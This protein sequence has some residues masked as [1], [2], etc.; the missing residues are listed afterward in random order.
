MAS[1]LGFFAGGFADTFQ[2][3]Q[4]LQQTAK[5]TN[6]LNDQLEL[7]KQA[8]Q[9]RAE[10]QES[11]EK[12][13]QELQQTQEAI[14]GQQQDRAQGA[15]T[16]V[17]LNKM[18]T[19]PMAQRGA[20]VDR[21]VSA[22][23]AEGIET[24]PN[25]INALKKTKTEDLIP[26]VNEWT[27]DVQALG[28]GQNALEGI[29]SDPEKTLNSLAETQQ[30]IALPKKANEKRVAQL[31]QKIN[32]WQDGLIKATQAENVPMTKFIQDQLERM[33]ETRANLM[34]EG[35]QFNLAAGAQR[36]DSAGNLIVENPRPASGTV[37]LALDKPVTIDQIPKLV[38]PKG[39][40]AQIGDTPRDLRER[41]FRVRSESDKTREA[42]AQAAKATLQSLEKLADPVFTGQEGVGN[43]IWDDAQ[44]TWNRIGQTDKDLVLFES[45]SNGTVAPLIRA[46]GE[47]GNMSNQDIQR[48]LALIP[49][50]GDGLTVLPD[51]R[52]VMQ[53]KIK[54]LTEWF[55]SA[56][57]VGK[58]T[59]KGEAKDLS[60][61]DLLKGF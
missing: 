28:I 50:A 21:W 38:G 42:Q 34:G 20:E 45:F 15:Q 37:N 56:L 14:K 16:I 46:V 8:A 26:M 27:K 51:T 49:Q 53:G 33:I 43:R 10:G 35:K 13:A 52:E 58:E 3:G 41:G 5:R 19:L 44:K 18:A 55:D 54:Q 6:I 1:N 32:Q 29:I 59:T 40:R 24:A 12:W 57:G 25:F 30:D 61:E 31:T 17:N 22:R 11:F 23:Q 2:R 60:D 36:R 39:E 48:G 9:K 4:A 47:K 7:Q